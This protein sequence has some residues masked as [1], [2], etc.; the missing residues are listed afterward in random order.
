MDTLS[1]NLSADPDVMHGKPVVEGTRVPVEVFLN[2]LTEG[3]SIE[4][5][6]E[7]CDL[8]EEQILA[9]VNFAADKTSKEEYRA[10][11]A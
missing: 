3:V 4:E 1:E 9:A 10:L 6:S 7:E 8:S 5:I 11:E 2:T